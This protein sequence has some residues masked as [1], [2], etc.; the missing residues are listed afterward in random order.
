MGTPGYRIGVKDGRLTVGPKEAITPMARDFIANYRNELIL[1]VEE[2]SE[3]G[4]KEGDQD[5]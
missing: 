4:H 1:W 3:N 2:H 5:V